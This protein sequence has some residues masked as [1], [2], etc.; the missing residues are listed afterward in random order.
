MH[1]HSQRRVKIHSSKLE[2]I[3]MNDDLALFQKFADE[4]RAKPSFAANYIDHGYKTGDWK[5]GRDKTIIN[6]RRLVGDC[7][8]TMIGRA[9]YDETTKRTEYRVVRVADNVPPPTRE[10]FG[11]LDTKYWKDGK[12]PVRFVRILSLLDL[13]TR[14]LSVYVASS[15]SGYDAIGAA[16][17]AWVH[18]C[19]AHPEDAGKLPLLEF[20][21]SEY[22]N[23]EGEK[24]Y[25]P[26]LDVVGW[27]EWPAGVRHITPPAPPEP[28]APPVLATKGN[29]LRPARD[30]EIPF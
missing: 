1:Q 23:K 13:E 16:V 22:T 20:A 11:F 17:G 21:S 29:G 18:N 26:L 15:F 10:E 4:A 28:P 25:D 8:G 2:E 19:T 6:G 14:E 27:V 5:T 3:P 30:D 7:P 9:R 12:D 24:N